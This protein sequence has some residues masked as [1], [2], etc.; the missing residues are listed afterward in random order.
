MGRRNGV[1]LI[2]DCNPA[3]LKR[4][5]E[6]CLFNSGGLRLGVWDGALP[7]SCRWLSRGGRP[8][9]HILNAP[10]NLAQSSEDSAN[11]FVDRLKGLRDHQLMLL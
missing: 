10:P 3:T 11:L 8:S 7:A 1:N 2:S 5:S 6:V 9:L 4:V